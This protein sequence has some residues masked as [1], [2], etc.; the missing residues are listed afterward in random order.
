M[1]PFNQKSDR[2]IESSIELALSVYQSGQCSSIRATA[3]AFGVSRNS[4]NRRIKG[5]SSKSMAYEYRQALS[6]AEEHILL[7]W[8]TQLGRTE[9]PISPLLARQMAEEIRHCRYQ[10][11]KS[12]LPSFALRPLGKNWLDKFRERHSEIKG[13]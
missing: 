1:A 8:I 6:T 13:I 7:K 9:Y 4:L 2:S 5:V 12:P 10:L 3:G 11:A